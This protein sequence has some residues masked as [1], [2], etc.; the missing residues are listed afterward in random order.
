MSAAGP[1]EAG[2]VEPLFK[3]RE[4]ARNQRPLLLK[5]DS[6]VI[7]FR[8]QNF[9]IGQS[10]NPAPFAVSKKN[11]IA[12]LR[13]AAAD[14]LQSRSQPGRR[15]GLEQIIQRI[16]LEG[17]QSV[18]VVSRRKNNIRHSAKPVEQIETRHA[19]HFDIEK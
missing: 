3:T 18:L 8:F 14:L 2:R 12:Q 1:E 9:D 5:K 15:D 13:V 11:L 10:H 19:G 17:L 6:R 4:R 7:A 16:D